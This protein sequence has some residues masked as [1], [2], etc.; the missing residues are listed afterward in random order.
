MAVKTGSSWPRSSF[1]ATVA[2]S[3]VPVLLHP[4]QPQ[5]PEQVRQRGRVTGQVPAHRVGQVARLGP[6]PLHPLT[7]VGAAQRAVRV[8]G[9][10]PVVVRVP[11][12]DL[13]GV[14]AGRQS[15]GDELADR[16]GDVYFK[17]G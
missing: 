3:P 15:L 1:S 16:Q 11:A 10:G 2:R 6:Q 14:G 8:L 9:Q 7:P 17:Y 5:D 12:A 13:G 4:E